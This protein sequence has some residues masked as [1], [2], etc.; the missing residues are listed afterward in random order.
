M[1][2]FG[3]LEELCRHIQ[4]QK[5]TVQCNWVNEYI[6]ETSKE[7]RP[8]PVWGGNQKGENRTQGVP[9]QSGG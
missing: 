4:N 8:P 2:Y 9:Q 1:N 6:K 5:G 3:S 7:K